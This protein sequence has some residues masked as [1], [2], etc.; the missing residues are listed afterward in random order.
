LT[1]GTSRLK[2]RVIF[3]EQKPDHRQSVSSSFLHQCYP[4]GSD[5]VGL[6]YQRSQMFLNMVITF[7]TAFQ[8]LEKIG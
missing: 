8:L 6:A 5:F 2:S 7:A 3:L 1:P 4:L